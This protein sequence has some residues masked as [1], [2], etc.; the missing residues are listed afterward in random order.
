VSSILQI[1]ADVRSAIRSKRILIIGISILIAGITAYTSRSVKG[2][3]STYSKIFPLSINKSG[4]SSPVDAIRAQFG[5]SDKTDYEK[6]YNVRE[7]V[8][9]KTI[10][11]TI[12]ASAPKNKKYSSVS[13]WLIEDYNSN[14]PFWKK[15]MKMPSAKDSNALHYTGAALLLSKTEVLN[16]VKTGFTSIY[17]KAHDQE[18]ALEMNQKILE[19]ISDYYIKLVTEKPRTDLEKIKLMRDSLQIELNQIERAIAGFID[20]NQLS[21]F[22]VTQLPQYKLLRMQ[23]E[24]EALYTTTATSYQN[25]KFKLLSESP[26]FQ[27]LDRAGA[28]FAFDQPNWKK[29]AVIAF[30]LSA[31]F[32]CLIVSRKVFWR[33]ILDELRAN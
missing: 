29:N 28:P 15:K 5:I 12:A 13:A 3:Y 16:D 25:A 32:M 24:I 20:A 10:S 7:L 19:A 22:S 23:K 27:V 11:T 17:T 8:T 30:F 26:I 31:L 4:G 6:I 2:T 9:S 1:A 14:A 21:P 33:M 18:L